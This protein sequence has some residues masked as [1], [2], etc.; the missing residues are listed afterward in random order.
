MT[1]QR[2]GEEMV[3]VVGLLRHRVCPGMTMMWQRLEQTVTATAAG[4][5]H[6]RISPGMVAQRR[7]QLMGTA[8][9]S[10][11]YLKLVDILQNLP[12][13]PKMI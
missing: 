6:Q 9:E 13:T 12:K 4:L 8:V 10:L 3:T 1:V 2:T 11:F 7:W 5:L